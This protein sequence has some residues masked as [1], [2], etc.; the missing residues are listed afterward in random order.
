MTQ[1]EKAKAYDRVSKEVKDFFEGRQKMYSD[2][3]KALEYLFPEL[4]ESEDERTRKEIISIVKSYRESC[5]TEGNHRFDDCIAWLEK[6]SEQN[7]IMANSPQ[8][9]EPKPT[10]KVKPKF[11]NGQWI[12]WQNKCYKVNYNGCG[13]ELIDQNGLSTSL[14]YGTID[15]SAHLWDVAKDAKDGDVLYTKG[16]Y[17]DCIFIFNGLDRWK[18]DELNGDRAVATGHCCLTLSGNGMEFSTQGPDCIEVD[19][20]TPATKKQCD[21][22]FAKVSYPRMNS[23]ACHR[24]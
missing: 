2:V 1:E 9:D 23:R 16:F 3:I 19:T 8:L 13:Y 10:D 21:T 24:H 11:Q 15:E 18:F 5:I 22:L 6:Q 4:A 17:G 7:L 20:V 12:V 14:E